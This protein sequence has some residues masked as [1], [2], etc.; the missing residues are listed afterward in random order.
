VDEAAIEQACVDAGGV[1]I[2]EHV[3]CELISE[4]ACADMGGTFDECASACRHEP[5]DVVCTANCVPL[6]TFDET[7]P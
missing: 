2:A 4:A 1:Y 6:C 5:E 7:M 3:E